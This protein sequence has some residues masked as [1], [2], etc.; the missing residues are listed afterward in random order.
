MRL[1]LGLKLWNMKHKWVG[2]NIFHSSKSCIMFRYDFSWL[3]SVAK[4]QY[5][6][7]HPVS[8]LWQS[9][10]SLVRGIADG[11]IFNKSKMQWGWCAVYFL[12]TGFAQSRWE[13]CIWELFWS[14]AP[15][16]PPLAPK[17]ALATTAMPLEFSSCWFVW[18]TSCILT[19]TI[20]ADTLPFKYNFLLNASKI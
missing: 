15:H 11:G 19:I 12:G 10:S 6:H 2:F 16:L 1:L 3:T 14:V 9:L 17:Y 8:D 7:L 20:L 13:V 4:E 5:C 18:M